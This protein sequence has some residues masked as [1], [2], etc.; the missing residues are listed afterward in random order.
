MEDEQVCK[1]LRK[2]KQEI[3][4]HITLKFCKN[5]NNI[6]LLYEKFILSA[7]N[8]TLDNKLIKKKSLY[9]ITVSAP[10]HQ[11]RVTIFALLEGQ[12]NKLVETLYKAKIPN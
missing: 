12:I 11:F 10:V 3:F 7:S 6:S 4:S 9:Q 2:F 1:S 5:R 8:L